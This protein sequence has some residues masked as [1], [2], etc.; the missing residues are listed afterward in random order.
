VSSRS[1]VEARGQFAK[2]NR[3][4]GNEN[5]R[6]HGTTRKCTLG[7]K[8]STKFCSNQDCALCNII[9]TSFNVSLAGSK[10][11]TRFGS[12]IYTSSASSK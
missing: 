7:D 1:S 10:N 11:G 2:A 5:R 3:S 12:G 8:G 6:W 9:R 4:A